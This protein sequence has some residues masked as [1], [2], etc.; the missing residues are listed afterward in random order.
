MAKA[1]TMDAMDATYLFLCGVMWRQYR[2]TD[3]RDELIR[4]LGSRDPDL[5]LL[6][7]ALLN[8]PTAEAAAS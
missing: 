1:M 3:A 7:K 2:Q 8:Q 5:R 6:A 4:A